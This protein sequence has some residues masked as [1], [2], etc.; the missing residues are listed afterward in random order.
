LISDFINAAFIAT[1]R[2]TTRGRSVPIL[3]IVGMITA[4]SDSI[5]SACD[6]G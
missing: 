1:R 6:S 2:L 3:V 4:T 5:F